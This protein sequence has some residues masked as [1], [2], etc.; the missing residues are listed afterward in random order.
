MTVRQ[1][2]DDH[3]NSNRCNSERVPRHRPEHAVLIS[4]PT[5]AI[6]SSG[7]WCALQN[8]VLIS[9][10]TGAIQRSR[11]GAGDRPCKPFQFQQVQFRV[12]NH[13]PQL[14]NQR[15]FQFQQVQFRVACL[16]LPWRDNRISI[17]TGAIQ[18]EPTPKRLAKL[19]GF[20][21]QQV[22]FRVG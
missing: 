12:R 7:V 19:L 4:I 5:G 18:S 1:R 14:F 6:Q 17:P 11:P 21:F 8:P 15:G 13:S 2:V 22:Q 20:Q 16:E 9:I 10:P 3:F